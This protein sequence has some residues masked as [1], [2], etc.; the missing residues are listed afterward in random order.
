MMYHFSLSSSLL[1][2]ENIANFSKNV[3]L[4]RNGEIETFNKWLHNDIQDVRILY[5]GCVLKDLV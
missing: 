2:R 5:E 3:P 4:K 1:L